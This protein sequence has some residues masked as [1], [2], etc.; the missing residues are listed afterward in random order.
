V[1][2]LLVGDLSGNN[3]LKTKVKASRHRDRIVFTGYRKDAPRIAGACSALVLPSESE[4][5]P[6]VVIEAMV[7]GRPVIVTE[8][9]GMPEL[10]N[11][12][13]EGYIVPVRAPKAL[14]RAIMALAENPQQAE[15]MG[16]RGYNRI[17]HGFS[18][19]QSVAET[20]ELLCEVTDEIAHA[21]TTRR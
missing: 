13:V 9:G 3:E 14:A 1:Y 10:V 5:L 18:V 20:R 6:R 16:Q 11:D 12:G 8:A 15:N 17:L 7:H 19:E 4:G 2:L 21:Q